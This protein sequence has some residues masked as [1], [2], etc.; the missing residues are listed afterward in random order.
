MGVVVCGVGVGC[1]LKWWEVFF[2]GRTQSRVVSNH[3]HAG[4][5]CPRCGVGSGLYRKAVEWSMV[6]NEGAEGREQSS[7]T[8]ANGRQ[9]QEVVA[10]L[11]R[12]HSRR[13]L[14]GEKK[15]ETQNS[16]GYGDERCG[17][18][19]AGSGKEANGKGGMLEGAQA[20]ARLLCVQETGVR[21]SGAQR[22]TK[23]RKKLHSR[24][25]MHSVATVRA[26]H[27]RERGHT[28][29]GELCVVAPLRCR[30]SSAGCAAAAAEGTR[31]A[32]NIHYC[33]GSA[34]VEGMANQEGMP[35]ARNM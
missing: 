19:S 11:G 23:K 5:W 14:N 15:G 35:C 12:W 6:V 34:A 9:V 26:W 27:A 30:H 10:Q 16:V 2:L 22:H 3:R 21:G 33:V 4:E 28:H 20:P 18:K 7:P 32:G 17:R 29:Q 24:I 13:N 1:V 31:A 25:G 8:A